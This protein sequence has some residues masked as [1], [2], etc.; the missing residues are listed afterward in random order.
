M[1][2]Q[3]DLARWEAGYLSREELIASYAANERNLAEPFEK[4][5]E[6]NLEKNLD[7]NV[8]KNLL[9]GVAPEL[10]LVK[11]LD[12]HERLVD[13]GSEPVPYH[14]SDWDQ[15]R[16]SLPD[17]LPTR[18]VFG[19]G[20]LARPLI[21]ASMV[22]GLTAG[23]AAA[24]PTV[25]QHMVSIWHG[26]QH[27]IGLVDDPIQVKV[28]ALRSPRRRTRPANTGGGGPVGTTGPGNSGNPGNGG[29]HGEGNSGDN[30]GDGGEHREPG[31]SDGT[32]AAELAEDL[33]QGR[34]ATPGRDTA[35]A[36]PATMRWT[37][38]PDRATA[39]A[40]DEGGGNGGGNSGSAAATLAKVAATAARRPRSRRRRRRLGRRRQ[41]SGPGNGGGGLGRG[42][43]LRTATA[44]EL[45]RRRRQLRK[46][47]RF[48][49][50]SQQ[51]EQPLL[52]SGINSD[53]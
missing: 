52:A 26:I 19:A 37:A 38:T 23:A 51:R 35:E 42:R 41:R 6:R 36:T 28:G 27:N 20:R 10:A 44:A 29:E 7:K 2:L 33:G 30:P 17:R 31:N 22:V 46:R 16:D 3:D 13:I 11:M 34:T 8:D 48:W 1:S 15:L 4:N 43:Q 9:P 18:R 5:L 50:R 40:P 21:A 39:E 32:P 53:A 12:L 25:R 47:R 49:G 24:S 45:G 14:E